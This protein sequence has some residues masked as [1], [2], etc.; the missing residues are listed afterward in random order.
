VADLAVGITESLDV[1]LQPSGEELRAYCQDVVQRSLAQG[2]RGGEERRNAVRQLLRSGG[3]KPSGRNK[4][5]QE[6]LLRTITEESS[7]PNILNAVDLINAVSLDCGLPISLI[8]LNRG[9]NHGSGAA[10]PQQEPAP[11]GPSCASDTQQASSWLTRL[12]LRYGRSGEC[13]T[14]NRTGQDL[15]VHGL[16]CLCGGAAEVPL[17][18]PVK[19]SLLAKVVEQDRHVVACIY[20]PRSVVS[21]DELHAWSRR[22]GEGLVQWCG[23]SAFDSRI[24]PDR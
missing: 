21:G 6:Y 18:T 23:A 7:L 8:A 2:L 22:L 15:N 5:A 1:Q 19:D 17:G 4:P 14:F 9:D 11:V 12:T 24:V 3:Y 16:I 10:A 13:Y 20:A